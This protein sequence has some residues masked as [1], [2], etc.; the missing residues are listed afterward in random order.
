VDRSIHGPEE[1]IQTNIVGTFRLLESVRAHGNT[2]EPAAKAS[3]RFL[4][5]STDEV[6]GDLELDG[7][8][9]IVGALCQE[10]IAY[11][12]RPDAI[13]FEGNKEVLQ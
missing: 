3:F 11:E 4:H 1:F 13:Y 8:G 7:K 2:L 10:C 6:Y 9:M 12:C 5:V